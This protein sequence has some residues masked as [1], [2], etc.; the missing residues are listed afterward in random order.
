MY[1]YIAHFKLSQY[2]TIYL[3]SWRN[4]NDQIPIDGFLS[5]YVTSNP[6][7]IAGVSVLP[8]NLNLLSNNVTC[9]RKSG[10]IHKPG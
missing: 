9:F 5:K 1:H 8:N 6:T 4:G 2:S 3:Y 10:L 7:E